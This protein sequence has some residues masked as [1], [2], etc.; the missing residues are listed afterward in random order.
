MCKLFFEKLKVAKDEE[1]FIYFTT[2]LISPVITGIKPSSIIN[3]T[4]NRNMIN[5][6]RENRDKFLSSLNLDYII[7]RSREDGETVLIYNKDNLSR[8]L[9]CEKI[10]KLLKNYGYKELNDIEDLLLHLKSRFEIETCPHEIGIFLGIPLHD[11][12]DFIN[13]S[14]KPCLLCK[15]W[16]VYSNE[17]YSKKIFEKYDISKELVASYL[18]QG[19]D[20]KFLYNN[21]AA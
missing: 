3:I 16:K 21:F 19:K 10:K 18:L 14:N 17:E 11:V 20:L 6:W 1:Y 15:Y 2:Y 13:C 8:A 9:K 4:S 12:E 7:I 5:I